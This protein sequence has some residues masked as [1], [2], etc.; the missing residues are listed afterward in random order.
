MT[1]CD[2]AIKNALIRLQS[3]MLTLLCVLYG[4]AMRI[5]ISH[6]TPNVALLPS[7]CNLQDMKMLSNVI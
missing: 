6:K 2:C 7:Q 4:D 1:Q 3:T 5:K